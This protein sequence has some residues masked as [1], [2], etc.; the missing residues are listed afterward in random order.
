MLQWVIKHYIEIVSVITGLIYLYFSV[1]QKIWL[2]PWGI[3][4]SAFCIVVFYE[5]QLYADMG[6][7]VYYLL[8]SI[9]GWHHW[10]LRKDNA[11]HD[12]IKISTLTISEWLPYLA[13]TLFLTIS[14][15]LILIN[16]PQKIGLLPSSVPWWDA[17]LTAGSIVA[18]WMLARKVLE[19][20]LWWIIIDSLSTGVF[21]YKELYFMAGL[22]VVYTIMSIVGYLKWK[23]DLKAQ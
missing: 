13:V 14:F 3:L 2:W 16:I 9:Y 8:I 21:L 15:A 20:W 11:S 4:T 18:T 19:Q 10:I 17:F 1:R 22:F 23:Q 6:L 5:K 7:N 12:S